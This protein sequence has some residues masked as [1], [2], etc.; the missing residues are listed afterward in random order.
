MIKNLATIISEKIIFDASNKVSYINCFD[1]V[2]GKVLPV[3]FGPFT[4][5][6]EWLKETSQ[7]YFGLMEFLIVSPNGEEKSV[8]KDEFI[9]KKNRHRLNF[10][11][12]ACCFEQFG[13]YKFI[14]RIFNRDNM[15]ASEAVAYI[16]VQQGT[17]VAEMPKQ[18]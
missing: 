9:M 4:V 14:F 16:D 18:G 8:T 15:L 1:I 6:S 10:Q 5:S 2:H 17:N 7:D 12:G 13:M 3:T 11:F